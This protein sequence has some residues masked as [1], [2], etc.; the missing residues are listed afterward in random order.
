VSTFSP[1]YWTP[2]YIS[3][4]ICVPE[5]GF[6]CPLVKLQQWVSRFGYGMD[7]ALKILNIILRG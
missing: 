2:I 7:F 6:G 3:R 5:L 1:K 4:G